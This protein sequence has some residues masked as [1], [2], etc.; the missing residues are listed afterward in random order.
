M[1]T[2][3]STIAAI[4]S[5]INRGS[6]FDAR[7]QEALV[8]AVNFY[9]GKRYGFNT[10]TKNF[11]IS[12]EYTTLTANFIEVD[13]VKMTVSNFLKPLHE[14]TY[15]QINDMMRDRSLSDEPTFFAIQDRTLRVYTPPGQ[16]Y[17]VEMHYIYDINTIS[18]STSDSTTTN[19][20]FNEGYELIKTHATIEVLETHIDGD[21]AVA[22]A[23]RLRNREV[24]VEKMLKK[25]ANREQSSS[26]VKGVI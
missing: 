17:S 6:A 10:K 20:W 24:E 26:R 14:R 8:N 15:L 7:I 23:I 4:R 11:S 22:K 1:A 16:S 9:R 18:L 21:D 19:A 25:R 2:L 5:D 3:G 13:Y 12:T